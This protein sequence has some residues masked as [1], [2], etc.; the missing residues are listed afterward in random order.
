MCHIMH[1]QLCLRLFIKQFFLIMN[2]WLSVVCVPKVLNGFEPPVPPMKTIVC[3]V[4]WFA[5]KQDNATWD[6][7]LIAKHQ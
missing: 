6:H 3:L 7:I 2:A 5:I 4:F 1:Y